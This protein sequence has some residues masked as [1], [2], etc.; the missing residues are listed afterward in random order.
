MDPTEETQPPRVPPELFSDYEGR[1]FQS[2]TR[3]G[4][5]LKDFDGGFQISKAYRNG[6]CVMEYALCDHCRGA[7]FAEFS[8]ESKEKLGHFQEERVHLERGFDQCAVCGV[9]RDEG[10]MKE[11]VVTGLCNGSRLDHGMLVCGECGDAVQGLISAKTRDTWRRFVDDNFPGPP[12]GDS[13]PLEETLPTVVNARD[14]RVKK[15][16]ESLD[17]FVQ[18][19]IITI[20]ELS[21]GGPCHP[22]QLRCGRDGHGSA[23]WSC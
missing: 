8:E 3:C 15:V 5:S 1:P 23:R 13:L 9:S 10:P 22:L 21:S 11:F 12:P 6:E 14:Q 16:M 4:E 19:T 7:M 18:L 2:C 17:Q 20:N